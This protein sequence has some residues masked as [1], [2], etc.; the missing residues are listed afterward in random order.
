MDFPPIVVIVAGIV[1]FV[2]GF[3]VFSYLINYL[4]VRRINKYYD[5]QVQDEPKKSNLLNTLRYY[6]LGEEDIAKG[7]FR[8]Y[9]EDKVKEVITEMEDSKTT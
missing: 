8:Y 5:V 4:T 3:I 2:V 6:E 9:L 7:Y 1:A